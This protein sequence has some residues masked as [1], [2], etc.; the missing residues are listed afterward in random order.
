M[1]ETGLNG[2]S[3]IPQVEDYRID[4][5][6]SVKMRPSLPTIARDLRAA[7]FR[8]ILRQQKKPLREDQAVLCAAFNQIAAPY[9]CGGAVIDRRPERLREAR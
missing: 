7:A 3:G 6:A 2:L 5:S 9:V 4:L 8:H 1:P